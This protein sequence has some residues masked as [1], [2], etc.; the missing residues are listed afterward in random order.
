MKYYYCS[1]YSSAVAGSL[2]LSVLLTMIP[3]TML[4]FQGGGADVAV[5]EDGSSDSGFAEMSRVGSFDV[6]YISVIFDGESVSVVD[7]SVISGSVVVYISV[8][9]CSV[10]VYSIEGVS[11]AAVYISSIFVE[12][13]VSVF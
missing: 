9:D 6:V 12:S 13:S 5:A 11:V 10:A 2:E 4:R 7:D 1:C 3:L 8:V